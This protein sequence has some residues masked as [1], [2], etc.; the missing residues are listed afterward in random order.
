M[1]NPPKTQTWANDDNMANP[2]EGP[3]PAINHATQDNSVTDELPSQPKKARTQDFLASGSDEPPQPMIVDRSEEDGE[4]EASAQEEPEAAGESGPVSDADWL[5]SKTSRLLGLL[6]EDEQAEFEQRPVEEPA[7]SPAHDQDESR[8]TVIEN[9]GAQ[10]AG[11][12]DNA[13]HTLPEQD[14]NTHLIRA[15]A[16]LFVRNLAYDIGEA[17]LQPLFAP[18]G[19]IDE[20]SG[21]PTN[22]PT[23][24]QLHWP[25]VKV[26]A[27]LHAGGALV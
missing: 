11:D 7:A 6:D 8:N 23:N 27:C 13:A 18:F 5:R 26:S 16:R 10:D 25:L 14:Q 20:V 21:R 15:S 12:D 9:I 19:K 2:S 24:P 4:K 17:D 3:A 22:P 1:Q